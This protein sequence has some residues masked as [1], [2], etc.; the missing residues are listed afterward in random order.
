MNRIYQAALLALALASSARSAAAAPALAYFGEPKYPPGFDHFDYVNPS[1]PRGGTLALS[2]VSQNSSFDKF[3]PFSLKGKPAPGLSELVFET[4]TVLSL[5]EPNTQYGLLADDIR[6]AADERSV[7]FHLHPAARFS[8]GSRL[9]AD[10]VRHSFTTLT[11]RRASP[12]FKAYF[13]EIEAVEVVDPETVRFRFER[14]GRD[15]AFV[16]GSL[17]VFSSRWGKVEGRA[18]VAFDELRFERPIA[19]GPYTIERATSGQDIVYLKNPDYWGSQTPSRRGMFHFQR[20][21]YKLYKDADTQVAALRAGEF[22]FFAETRM[23]YWCCQFIGQRFDR[24]ELLK[25]VVPHR[26]PP[27]MNGWVVNLRKPRFQDIRVREALNLAQDF[28][29]VND[30]IFAGEF[31]RV[32]SY[33]SGTELA[34]TGLPGPDELALLEP[35]RGEIPEAAFGPMYQQPTT[36]PPSSIRGNLTRALELLAQAGWHNVDGELRNAAGE[37]FVLTVEGSRKQNPYLDA[38]YNNLSK[39]GIQLRKR[40]SDAASSRKTVN[41]FDFDFASIAL[42]ES[43]MP[44]PELWRAF[45]SKDADVAGSENIIGVRSA[46]VDELIQLILDAKTEAAQRSAARALDRVLIHSHYVVPWRYLTQHYLIY[47]ERLGRPEV[48]PSFYNGYDWTMQTWWDAGQSSA[49]L[50]RAPTGDAGLG[51]APGKTAL[52]GLAALGAVGVGLFG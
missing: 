18:P 16:A 46:A 10:D 44:G 50:A 20:V 15:L 5:D 48:R 2:I 25:E 26:N 17:P 52:L 37:P 36:R 32:T 21:T 47:A 51:R 31:E 35:H 39:L 43:R 34:A 19:T 22:D 41:E 23:R 8:D 6:L 49:S 13:G 14:A 28:E 11:G 29:W 24:G 38:Y 42:R 3:N 40:V 4:L 9:T 12:R 45:N 7:E 1:A 27:A 30:K 33:F